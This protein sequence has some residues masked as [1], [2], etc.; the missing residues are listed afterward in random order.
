MFW[1]I[2]AR[3]FTEGLRQAFN[4][5]FTA[6]DI[7][8]LTDPAGFTLVRELGF[9]NIAMGLVGLLSIFDR[10]WLVP[11]ASSAAPSVSSPARPT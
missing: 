2:G 4:P 6:R 8:A 9:A 11:V 7:F 5:A 10:D 3:L 1:G